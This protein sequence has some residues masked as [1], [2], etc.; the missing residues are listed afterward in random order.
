M[1]HHIGNNYLETFGGLLVFE[2]AGVR[3]VVP[4]VFAGVTRN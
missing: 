3:A 1:R 2:Q 4:G